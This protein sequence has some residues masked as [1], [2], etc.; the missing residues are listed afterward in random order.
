MKKVTFQGIYKWK[1]LYNDIQEQKM[2]LRV[3]CHNEERCDKLIV[4]N[5]VKEPIVPAIWMLELE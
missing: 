5:Q 4:L 1:C 2:L 3:K